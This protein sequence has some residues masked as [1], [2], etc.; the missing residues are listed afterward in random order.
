VVRVKNQEGI[1][2][3]YYQRVWLVG[4]GRDRKHHVEK[5]RAVAQVVA[6]VHD[7]VTDGLLVAEGSNGA[8]LREQTS[9]VVVGV[10]GGVEAIWVVSRKRAHHR[11]QDRHGVTGCR[12]AV[13]EA[14]HILVDDAVV[15][16]Q[17]R[18]FLEGLPGRQLAVNEEVGNFGKSGF[19]RELLDWYAAIAKDSLLT[20]KVGDGALG[21][22]S[23][24]EATVQGHVARLSAESADI[25][26]A[27]ALA[28]NDYREFV[29]LTV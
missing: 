21:G 17:L 1:E 5:V 3:F 4:F 7:R 19:F 9:D 10:A 24:A 29:F 8:Y 22:A 14:T 25:D 23:V 27:F 16:E 26:G 18:E 2:G 15:R 20:I 13:E 12:E 28:A 6:R 11:R